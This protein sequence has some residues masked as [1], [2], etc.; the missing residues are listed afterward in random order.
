[1]RYNDINKN[2]TLSI[3]FAVGEFRLL[4]KKFDGT[5]RKYISYPSQFLRCSV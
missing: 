5:Q 4:Q 1:M 3:P 2:V